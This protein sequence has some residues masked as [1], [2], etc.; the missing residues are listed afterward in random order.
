MEFEKYI[1]KE[2]L[3]LIPVMYIIGMGLKKSKV[4]DKHIPL[5]LGTISVI[6]S[7]LWVFA[8][9]NLESGKEI[10]AA[11]F[12]AVTQGVLAAGASV[13]ASQLYIQK[14]KKQ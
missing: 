1:R 13:Y 7:A 12:T 3:I 4:A 5:I 11:F 10:L 9:A 8:P 6:L 2:L 14:N